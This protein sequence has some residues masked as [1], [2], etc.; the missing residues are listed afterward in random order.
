MQSR[1]SPGESH[2]QRGLVG[3]PWGRKESDTTEQ[4]STFEPMVCQLVKHRGQW[5]G[6]F[7]DWTQEASRDIH[8]FTF[9]LFT[10]TI[11]LSVQTAHHSL[12]RFFNLKLT[13]R[14]EQWLKARSNSKEIILFLSIMQQPLSF[15]DSHRVP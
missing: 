8:S 11:L 13:L 9:V 4:L 5:P 6:F 2:G 14:L 15:F 1:I 7:Q 12:F 10:L 3:C